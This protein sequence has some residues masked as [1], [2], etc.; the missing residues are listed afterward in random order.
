MISVFAAFF[1]ETHYLGRARLTCN[2]E[3]DQLDSGGCPGFVYHGPHGLDHYFALID[4]NGKNLW[5][6][7]FESPRRPGRSIIRASWIIADRGN[8]SHLFQKMGHI[9]LT[10]HAD[11]RMRA[12]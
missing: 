12:Q 5:L 2:V 7:A 1:S 10:A 3:P 8:T 6:A 4:W 9:H 11:G